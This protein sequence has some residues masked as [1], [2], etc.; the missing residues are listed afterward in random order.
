MRN[1]YWKI[2]TDVSLPFFEVEHKY[3]Q[4]PDK[5]SRTGILIR[6]KCGDGLQ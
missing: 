2:Y 4:A 5:N 3:S 6:Y 1:F